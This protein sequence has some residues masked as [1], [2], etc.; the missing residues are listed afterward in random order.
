[1]VIYEDEDLLILN[2]PSGMPSLPHSEAELDDAPTAVGAALSHCPELRQVG[3]RPLEPGL[4]HRLDTGTSGLL[5]FA[6][7]DTEY[8]RLRLAW[9][10]GRVRKH[11][12]AWVRPFEPGTPP[13]AIPLRLELEL[14]HDVSSSRRMR[15]VPPRLSPR[16]AESW[17]RRKL[18]GKAL[19]TVTELLRIHRSDA[20]RLDLEVAIGTGVMHQI[21][22]TL[23][24][25]GWP[26]VGDP[27]YRVRGGS[28]E[29]GARL[30]LHAWKL[31]LPLR[32]GA[33]LELMAALP[34]DWDAPARRPG[35]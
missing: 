26:I 13:P 14:G 33:T 31:G 1:M 32:D 30:W 19:P 8:E 12:R 23:Q 18:R 27:V 24:F 10:E 3:A 29:P 28:P 5:A 22:A 2:K 20:A 6:K 17:R 34:Q 9:R 21:R 16:E 4:L 11:Y 7:S 35:P 25:L 15:V